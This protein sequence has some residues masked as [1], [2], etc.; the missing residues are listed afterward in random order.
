MEGVH[1]LELGL[2]EPRSEGCGLVRGA[3][4][5]SMPGAR[6]VGLHLWKKLWGLELGR[7]GRKLPA[8]GSQIEL[9]MG[10]GR[11][12]LPEVTFAS[13]KSYFEVQVRDKK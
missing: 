5:S 7:K 4:S 13:Q 2:R 1:L 8:E 10:Q 3:E 11:G 6:T 12:L 9:T